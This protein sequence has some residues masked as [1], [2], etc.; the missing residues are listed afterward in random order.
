MKNRILNNLD[1]CIIT[2]SINRLYVCNYNTSSGII[3]L[4]KDSNYFLTDFRYKEEAEAVL[5]SKNYKILDYN[6][7]TISAVI[8]AILKA[9]K[10]KSVGLEENIPYTEYKKTLQM[11][12]N[13]TVFDISKTLD[14][15]RSVKTAKELEHIKSAQ[16]ITDKTLEKIKGF[17]KLGIT[18]RDLSIELKYQLLKNGADDFAF[19]PIVAFSK[20]TSKPHC[21]LSDTKL[22]N[23][24]LI[25]LDFGAKVSNYCSD[26]TR[27]LSFGKP[28]ADILSTY[29]LVLKAQLLALNTLKNNV[30]ARETDNLVRE[31]FMA[32]GYYENFGHGLGHGVGLQI[33]ENP[34][35]NKKTEDVLKTNMVVTIEPGLYFKNS[36]GIRIEDLVVIKDDGIE[37]LTKSTKD[38]VII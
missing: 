30:S 5:V 27:M 8:N 17:I 28:S 23:G 7:D 4:T 18:E 34:N 16:N 19:E 14:E 35:L 36:Y 22:E 32:N 33:H 29:K 9:E 2:S 24:D 11:L 3:I 15:I 37:N 12:S 38:L 25:M 1:A 21:L 10:V 6:T 13:Y 26:M 31:I 20:N